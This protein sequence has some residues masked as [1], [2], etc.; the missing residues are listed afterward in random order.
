ML[1]KITNDCYIDLDKVKMVI[2]TSHTRGVVIDNE[3]IILTDVQFK[4]LCEVLDKQPELKA[5]KQT[6]ISRLLA[7]SY[8]LV[9]ID[10]D[11]SIFLD[12]KHNETEE[13]K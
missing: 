8:T 2:N 3:Q 7:D 12:M 9:P 11:N 6:E 13:P 5:K 1:T 10:W 4:A